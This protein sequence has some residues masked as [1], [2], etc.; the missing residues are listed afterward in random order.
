MAAPRAPEPP[1][2]PPPPP[3]NPLAVQVA[4]ALAHT[5]PTEAVAYIDQ[6]ADYCIAHENGRVFDGWSR[7]RIRQMIAYHSAKGTL[8]GNETT[9]GEL[10]SI[11]MWYRCDATDGWEWVRNWQPDR[12]QGDTF[13][14]AFIFTTDPGA[15]AHG[16]LEL[17][18]REPEVLTKK[19][20]AVRL[21]D[22]QPTHVAYD[23]R[24]F[25]RILQAGRRQERK[26]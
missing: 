9:T 21:R 16:T 6:L 11:F 23:Q 15:L 13:W 17:I 12:P 24:L 4:H 26:K 19:L 5:L 10:T 3:A 1:R 8:L 2:L 25:V 22:G 7:E 20:R 14:L 18:R